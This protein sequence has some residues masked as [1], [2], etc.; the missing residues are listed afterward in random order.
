MFGGIHMYDYLIVGSGLF[1]AVFAHEAKNAGKSV[2]VIERRDHVGGNIYCEEMEG[3]NVYKYGAHIFHT[4]Y[5]M[6]SRGHV[7]MWGISWGS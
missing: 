3:I 6:T 1:G 5:L 7:M 4:S 2:L